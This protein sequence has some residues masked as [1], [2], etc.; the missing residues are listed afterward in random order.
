MSVGD[1]RQGGDR[2]KLSGAQRVAALLIVLGKDAAPRLLDHL[3]KDEIAEVTRAAATLG[4]VDRRSLE[5]LI[6]EFAEDLMRGPEVMGTLSEAQL[7]A[8]GRLEPQE[9]VRIV[10]G[11]DRGGVVDVWQEMAR[12]TDRRLI[13]ALTGEPSWIL[14]P[15][16]R[17]LGADRASA[18][19]QQ[20]DDTQR[21]RVLET[22]LT[23]RPVA[24]RV[25]RW[26]EEGLLSALN[27]GGEGDVRDDVHK[28]IAGILNRMDATLVDDAMAYLQTVAP[29][30]TVLVRSMV[31][32]FEQIVS[33]SSKSRL[34]LF[35]GA[36]AE[37]VALAL[38]GAGPDLVEAALGS[39][40]ARARRMVETEL[41]SDGQI[42]QRE[43]VAARRMIVDAALRLAEA[44][45][46]ELP[47]FSS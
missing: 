12:M 7:L 34:V 2:R 17:R 39:L 42:A 22:M 47:A 5:K 24:P 44:G 4:I 33:L 16:L 43:I 19:L 13:D 32:Q 1:R 8:A 15:I 31:F 11:S 3:S 26:L 35:D 38:K 10:E 46:L 14:G 6:D 18:I 36:P 37:R 30:Q 41:A 27:K 40:G 45:E 29:E 21:L 20:L 23:G 28:D 9:V 25:L